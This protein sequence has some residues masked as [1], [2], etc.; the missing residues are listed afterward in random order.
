MCQCLSHRN[1]LSLISHGVGVG[2]VDGVG[3]GGAGDAAV[4]RG[5]R[6]PGAL[7]GEKVA[8]SRWRYPLSWC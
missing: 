6:G 3:G 2:G 8:D 7:T 5:D 1:H 4:V